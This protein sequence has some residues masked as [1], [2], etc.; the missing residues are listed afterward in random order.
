MRDITYPRTEL[1]KY[2][3]RDI[4]YP[5]TELLEYT[6]RNMKIR[7]IM[8]ETGFAPKIT[9]FT[10]RL[11]VFAPKTPLFAPY[12]NRKLL[13]FWGVIVLVPEVPK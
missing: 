9:I 3:M 6:V 8:C 11:Y 5:R 7:N 2:A 10:Q 1:S 12:I 4:Q 13:K